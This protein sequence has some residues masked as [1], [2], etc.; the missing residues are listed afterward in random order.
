VP[1]DSPERAARTRKFQQ[2]NDAYYTLS[3]PTRRRDYD[4]TRRYHGFGSA[5]GSGSGSAPGSFDDDEEVPRPDAGK[6]QGG[7]GG[8]SFPWSAFGF[9]GQAKTEEDAN[10]F[11]SEQFGNVF[12]EMLRY[13]LF[14]FENE[15]G[16]ASD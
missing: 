9:G 2:I 4:A 11:S 5:F 13:V 7:G 16:R 6:Q 10:K 14:T 8:F 15:N 1:S 12:E 3:D